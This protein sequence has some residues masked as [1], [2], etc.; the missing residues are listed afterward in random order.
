MPGGN[1]LR[2]GDLPTG[3]SVVSPLAGRRELTSL[4]WARAG[5]Q[6]LGRKYPPRYRQVDAGRWEHRRSGGAGSQ[7]PAIGI[8]I[9]GLP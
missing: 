2:R 5:P 9:R 8:C 1:K 4:P 7:L 3:E 6:S